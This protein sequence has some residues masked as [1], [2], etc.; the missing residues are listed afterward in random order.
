MPYDCDKL[1]QLFDT[2][3]KNVF[4]APKNNDPTY[5]SKMYICVLLVEEI[6][7]KCK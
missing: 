5:L 3:K 6:N 7:K 4:C 2:C 1:Q